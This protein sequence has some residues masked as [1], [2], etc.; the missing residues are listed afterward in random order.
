VIKQ[1][2]LS[3]MCI[4]EPGFSLIA[5]YILL[6]LLLLVSTEKFGCGLDYKPRSGGYKEVAKQIKIDDSYI[7]YLAYCEIYLYGP[8]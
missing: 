2:E 4:I 6:K 3:L 7:G 1:A 8:D 5:K